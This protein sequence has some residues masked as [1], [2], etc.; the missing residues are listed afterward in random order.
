[1]KKINYYLMSVLIVFAFS[2][3][4][5][6]EV[7]PVL[8]A[9]SILAPSIATTVQVGKVVTMTFGVNA[10]GKVA[11]VSVTTTGGEAVLISPNPI[12]GETAGDVVVTYTAPIVNDNYIVTLSVTDAQTPALSATTNATVTVTLGATSSSELLVAKFASAPTLDG[13]IDD[14]WNL[15]QRLVS[16]AEVPTLSARNTYLNSDGSGVEE[17]LGLF[18]PY[19]EPALK[20]ENFTLRSGYFGSDIYFLL[21]WDDDVDS[22][23]RQSWYFDDV[24][25]LWK[26]EHK[27]ANAVD[28]QFYEDKFAFLFPIGPV[29][30]FSA[31]TCYATCHGTGGTITNPKDKHTR[32]YLTKDGQ[33]IDMWHWKRVRGTHN[34]RIDDQRIKYVTP[35]YTSASNGRGGD[36]DS[37][38]GSR[39]G[40]SNNKQT[41]N[42]G[43]IDVSVPLYVIPDGTDYYWIPEAQLDNEAVKVTG[44][45]AKG[46]LTL[47][48]GG[49]ID[50]AGDAGYNQGTGN[51]RFPSI[52]T[53]DFL[54]ERADLTIK[55]THTGTGW[56]AEFTRKLNTGDPWDV[57]FV[58]TEELP[59]GLAIF[60]N[61]AIAHAIKPGL[62]LKFEQ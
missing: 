31:S 10:P 26:Q 29:D 2:C 1:M 39:S 9:P 40:Y 42:N 15:A 43:T 32:H 44:V 4:N 3:K 48:G 45:D 24:N 33:K 36:P 55:V 58:T 41:L 30:G 21:E 13:E 35:P 23:D 49:T 8:D 14:I 16:T 51:K 57:T 60:D 22:K 28:D 5:N 52:L 12:I 6:E 20:D 25:E 37:G 7:P 59:F 61:A 27:Y 50:P 19:S 46:V 11:T 38:G 18:F 17:G 56:V 54:G 53:R 34:D 62:N 47:L